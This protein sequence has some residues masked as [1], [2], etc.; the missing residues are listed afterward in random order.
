[1]AL[2]IYFF[3]I[4]E[5]TEVPTPAQLPTRRRKS[6]LCMKW[7]IDLFIFRVNPLLQ[8]V[9]R[10]IWERV[11]LALQETRSERPIAPFLS[12]DRKQENPRM[13]PLDVPRDLSPNGVPLPN[14]Y[15]SNGESFA[16]VDRTPT[17]FSKTRKPAAPTVPIIGGKIQSD[18]FAVSSHLSQRR[19]PLSL[20]SRPH[21]RM[22]FPMEIS[23]SLKYAA[24]LIL[25]VLFRNVCSHSFT[26][27]SSKGGPHTHENFPPLAPEGGIEN[28]KVIVTG[29][30]TIDV[31]WTVSRG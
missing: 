25:N 13:T 14:S 16:R 11:P 8:W 20:L 10:Q 6:L 1:M 26:S 23:S 29:P 31:S 28:F 27:R 19:V 9:R 30:R 18:R 12:F 5:Q 24:E 21:S 15:A 17:P 7:N 2:T 22:S 3:P 4:D